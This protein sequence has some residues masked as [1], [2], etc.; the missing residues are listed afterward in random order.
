MRRMVY[1]AAVL[2]DN[3][4]IKEIR[5]RVSYDPETGKF[6]W[7]HSDKMRPC[8]NSRFVGKN[9][10]NAPHS[11]GYLFGAISDKKVF[12]HRAA[13]AIIHGEWPDEGEIDHINHD[14]TDNRVKNLR[15]VNRKENS[16]N[17][18]KSSKNKSGVT[19]VFKHSQT[20]IWQAQ[21]RVN[22]KSVH[23][24]SFEVFEDAVNARKNAEEY[25]G[26][27]QNHGI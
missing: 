1:G 20:G 2:K 6:T 18:S 3:L 10:I 9:A 7:L 24:G 26:F 15:L 21:I 22:G 19:G 13:W 11:N 27:H 8:W 5:S 17:L 14:K 12:A 25:H 16:K 23:L 4:T